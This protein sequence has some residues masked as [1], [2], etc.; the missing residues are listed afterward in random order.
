MQCPTRKLFGSLALPPLC[1]NNFLHSTPL[2]SLSMAL[3]TTILPA[4][5]SSRFYRKKL[6]PSTNS[7]I[8][9]KK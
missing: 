9:H 5:V 7:K 4:N 6:K 3:Q 1:R 8:V 2:P